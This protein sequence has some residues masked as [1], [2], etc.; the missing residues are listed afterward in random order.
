M[1]NEQ[2]NPPPGPPG[3]SSQASPGSP[4]SPSSPQ[5]PGPQAPQSPGS[6][7]A[8]GAGPSPGGQQ[9]P[10]TGAQPGEPGQQGGLAQQG[11]VQDVGLQPS[12]SNLLAYFF[13]GIGGLIVFLT[14]RHP[15]QRF[16]GAQSLL[17]GLALVA[18]YIVLTIVFTVFAF[19]DPTGGAIVAIIGLIV[20]TLLPVAWL[21]LIIYMCVQGYKERHVKLPV[22]GNFAE[23][24]A[25]IGAARP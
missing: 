20:Y 13:L 10:P 15:E 6:P 17:L 25:G 24:W 21:V 23:Q 1:A 7:Q 14:Q 5:S 4:Q 9:P 3:G 16:H 2:Q 8:P 19:V 11:P 12:V 22:V 18:L